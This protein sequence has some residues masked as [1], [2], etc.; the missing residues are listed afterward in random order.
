MY[1]IPVG[2]AGGGGGSSWANP[3]LVNNYTCFGGANVGDG[4]VVIE[5]DSAAGAGI[6]THT[7]S[8][9]FFTTPPYAKSLMV[10]ANGAASNTAGGGCGAKVK[11]PLPVSFMMELQVS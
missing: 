5:E 9:Q 1:V 2:V 3:A 8:E 6:F 10:R 4:I 11:A 7:A